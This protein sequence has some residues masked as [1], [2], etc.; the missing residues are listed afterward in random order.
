[1]QITIIKLN[2][3]LK[4]HWSKYIDRLEVKDRNLGVPPYCLLGSRLMFT[5]VSSDCLRIVLLL[6]MGH[7]GLNPFWWKSEVDLSIL[8][9]QEVMVAVDLWAGAAAR[10]LFQMSAAVPMLSGLRFCRCTLAVPWAQLW[11]W[12]LPV[13]DG[14]LRRCTG[15]RLH[16]SSRWRWFM[17][18]LHTA[19]T[20]G[21]LLVCKPL[22]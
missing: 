13:P 3:A 8:H 21:I 2:T 14:R 19:W 17:A 5:L 11:A 4:N 1:M 9:L 10:A 20:T 12:C 15:V 18:C 7:V 16:G 6:E 22:H